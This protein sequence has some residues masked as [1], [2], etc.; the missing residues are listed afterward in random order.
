MSSQPLIGGAGNIIHLT[1]FPL[2]HNHILR[3]KGRG[4]G[5]R[6]TLTKGKREEGRGNWREGGSEVR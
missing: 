6:E 4:R 5:G 2:T 3:L 1:A